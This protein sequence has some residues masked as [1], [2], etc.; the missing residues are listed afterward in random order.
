MCDNI[1]LRVLNINNIS[2]DYKDWLNNTNIN[3][4]LESRFTSHRQDSVNEFVNNCSSKE[5]IIL[6]G[7]FVEDEH[8]GNIKL[9]IEIHHKYAFVGILIGNSLYHNKGIATNSINM[10]LDIAKEKGL[11]KILAG[12]YKNNIASINLF[13]KCGFNEVGCLKKHYLY[14]DSYVDKII[15]EIIL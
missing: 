7:I 1:S 15:M 12:I 11:N 13:Q 2:K 10:I 9:D 3:Q 5:N 4:Y 8:I 14:K 6:R